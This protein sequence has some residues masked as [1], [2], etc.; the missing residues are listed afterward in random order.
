M[1]NFKK[2]LVLFLIFNVLFTSVLTAHGKNDIE[3]QNADNVNSW[4]E[5]FDLDERKP[6]KYNIMITARDLG[7]NTV[8]EG[9]HNIYYDPKSDLPVCGI[10]NPYPN[11]RVVSNLNIV[12]TCVDD[13]KVRYVELILDGDEE[14]P[15]K[16]EGAEF[17]SYYLN[18][19]DLEEGPHTIKV[20]GYD[21]NGLAGNPVTL[22]WQLDRNQPLTQIVD[23]EMGLLV[24]GNV[25]FD[26][27][28]SDG[29]GIKT[30]EYS[31]D[32][33]Q[34]FRPVKIND[35]KQ[36]SEFSISINTKEYPDG[37]AILW[38]RATDQS[39]SVG[40][41]SFLYFIDNTKPDVKIVSPEDT[42]FLNGKYTVAGYAKDTIGVTELSWVYGNQ[43]GTIDL[44]P[45]NPYWAV[46]L[47]STQTKE[48][49]GKFTIRAVD[50]AKNIVEVTKVINFNQDLDKPIATIVEPVAAQ[51]FGND[52]A[53]YLRGIAKDDDGIAS[54][55]VQLD[56]NEPLIIETKGVFF[57][58]LF[59][60]GQIP[61]G[62]HRI[63]VQPTDVNGVQGDAVSVEIE[64]KGLA[65]QFSN[66]KLA[67]ADFV[68]GSTVHPES[69]SNFEVTVTSPVG[70][71]AIH[72]DV[73]WGPS[74]IIS[75]DL[76]P[77]NAGS[78][79]VVFPITADGP[80]GLMQYKITATDSLE[81]VSTYTAIIYI[82]NTSVVKSDEPA[83][84]LD[85]SRFAE[86]GS[87]INNPDFPATAYVIGAKASKVELVPST[88]F[89]SAS[90]NGNQI[91]LKAGNSIGSSSDVIIKVTTDKGKTI[92]SK[93]IRFKQ[94]TE[95]PLITI[96]N[97]EENKAILLT[98]EDEV[99]TVSGKVSCQTGVGPVKYRIISALADMK[100]GIIGGTRVVETQALE[101][102][103]LASNGTFKISIPVTDNLTPGIHVVE[104]VA[105]SAGGNAAANAIAYKIMPE[106]EEINGK[107][108]V[109]K[110]PAVIF[111][112]AFDGYAAGLYQGELDQDFARFTRAD[113]AEGANVRD[114]T[115]TGPDGKPV[116]GKYTFNKNPTLTANLALI[117]GEEYMSGMPI[118]LAY[119][120]KI[121]GTATIYIDTGATVSGVSYEIT[122]AETAG[123]DVRQSGNAKLT[124]P[125]PGETRWI[126]EIP[127]ANLPSRVNNITATI[128]AGSLEQVV[129]G[130][131]TVIREN[132]EEN[133]NDA[134][135]IYNYPAADTVF[136]NKEGNYVLSNGSKF[137]YYANYQLP[138]KVE[139][140]SNTPG[141]ALSTEGRLITLYAEKDGIY[142]NVQVKVTDGIGDSHSSE[143]LNFIADTNN[144]QLVLNT[145]S[146]Y[147]WVRNSVTISGTAAHDLG[148]RS[149]EYSID[150]GENWTNF[151]IKVSQGVTFNEAINISNLEDGLVRINIRATDTA[152]HTSTV[153]TS[154]YKDTVAPEVTI[155][156]PVEGDLVNGQNLIVFKAKD[157]SCFVKAEYVASSKNGKT[158][159]ELELNPLT[160]TFVGT[161]E[162]PIEEG[163]S[164]VFSD[165]AG[166][167]TTINDWAFKIDNASDLPRAEIHVPEEMQV[168]TRDFT[169]SGVV[170]DDDGE[171]TIYYKIDNGSYHKLDQM[172]TSFAINVPL[173]SMTDNE[174][175]VTIYAEDLNGV[176][177]E[178][179]KRTFRISLEEPKGSVE[180]PTIDTSV[181]ELVQI[182]G[183]ASD[184]NGIAKVQVSLDNGNSYN[185]AVGTENWSYSV[186]TRAIPGGTQVVFLKVTD[187]YGIQGLYS[188]LIN[189]DNDAP[190]MVLELPLDD[191]ATTGTLFLS[192]YTYDNLD[193]SQLY[194]TIRNLEKTTTAVK[195]DIRI[196]RIIAESVDI[197]DLPDGFYN[198]ELTG[199]D[200]AGNITNI[201]RNIHLNKT[202]NAAD[203]DI[204][205]PLNGEHKNGM[206]AI[207]GQTEA[208]IPIKEL[209]L[210]LDGKQ[211]ETT[212]V[213][214]CNFFRFDMGNV[215]VDEEGNKTSN[216]TAGPHKYRV[217]ALLENGKIV[218]SREQTLTYS[219]YGPWVT[220]DNFTYGDF[221]TNRPFITGRAGYVQDEEEIAASKAKDASAEFKA[222][223]ALKKLVKVELSLDNGKTFVE[224]SD[225]EKWKYRVENEDIAEGYHFILVRATMANGETAINR[226]I[227]QVDNSKPTIKLIS[228]TTGGRYNQI[229]DVQGLSHDDVQLEDVT[230]TL[231]KGDKASYEVPAFIQGLY[232]DLHFWG[233]TLYDIGA[234]L[235]FFDDNV[236][237]QGQWGQFTQKQRDAVSTMLN[238]GSTAMR[239]GG[240]HV[241]GLKILANITSI[242]FSFFLGRDWEWLYAT[243]AVG[244]QFSWFDQTASGKTQ[245][246]SALLLQIE[247][248]KVKIKN[249]KA[250]ST[251]AFYT[252][253]S[254]WFIPT[255][256]ASTIN[257]QSLIPQIAVGFR[258]NVF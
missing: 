173:S 96:D 73:T 127:L 161:K 187:N 217:D 86:D 46:D 111:L 11:M 59:E 108:P 87:V 253:G 7:G 102:V 19:L 228:P 1:K 237:L 100:N 52:D 165:A 245:T 180:L 221:A 42:E 105:E 193:V 71:K 27:V 177:G 20:I 93:A 231:R 112:D 125:L 57:A 199:K 25:K 213:T 229:L 189:I 33:G 5:L 76:D 145:P 191:S 163:M 128:K 85:D 29:N 149:V 24:S 194:I 40:L 247:F 30:L 103:T 98:E 178:E 101:P 158:R 202:K 66:A 17:W 65:P 155:V 36:S 48:K 58:K 143:K 114:F 22:T 61:A 78:F 210:I 49:S 215:V 196:D 133:I 179:T 244:A 185:D 175:T 67:K 151:P 246:L 254:L 3:E 39:G 183:V 241:L 10:T 121:G 208:E 23:K 89:A 94:D 211:V 230:V 186:D 32:G 142:K 80:K 131:V 168:I 118:T 146:L 250:F 84:V 200:K 172:G 88:P 164:F 235:T 4:Q 72:T 141:L 224:L 137:Y 198:I 104:V 91:I 258:T 218:Q 240:D 219:P 79:N 12:G 115:V 232:L 176:R 170:Y 51:I 223:V 184:K 197:S 156:E 95:L 119:G 13:D 99:I 138:L 181:R 122:G 255:D 47:D 203:V 159:T 75:N 248:P 53:L 90:L 38:F 97:A 201:S 249:A 188:S 256:V 205:Y 106:I 147:Q 220:I 166:N 144:P 134:E 110:A 113:M 238:Q 222:A 14:N 117:N 9:P 227:I 130:A 140:V 160:H 157:E 120:D 123:G 252:E 192:G 153:L 216:I 69:N 63:T 154:C 136:D 64:S 56:G 226:I 77:K 206:F 81:R 34:Y 37:P 2:N 174:H 68:N 21:I 62:K 150:G 45:G 243:F 234:G 55:K 41:Y 225:T 152:G 214:D 107:L 50:L 83:I 15:I 204:L 239:Y 6:G 257:I 74:G 31:V 236:K 124:K 207:Y 129:K 26:G 43:S 171:S 182:S 18:T 82:T 44:V 169:I 16:A 28:V 135:R 60:E 251:F 162:M 35:K 233:A 132:P 195:R 92:T 126:A 116:A 109:A 212:A 139:L 242:P 190:Y 8:V 54:V 167:T 209:R 70:L 148:I